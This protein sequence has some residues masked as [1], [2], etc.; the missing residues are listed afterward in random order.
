MADESLAAL[1]T[2]ATGSAA[3]ML[4]GSTAARVRA[5]F[6]EAWQSKLWRRYREQAEEDRGFYVGGEGQWAVGD[7]KA[8]LQ[9]IK[10]LK[11]AAV[12]YNHCQSVV[13]VLTGTERQNRQEIKA[14]PQG[15][16]DVE[17]ARILTWLLKFVQDQTETPFKVSDGFDDGIIEG[18]HC[19]KVGIDFSEDPARGEIVLDGLR[20]GF[21][22]IWDPFW[23]DY[24][25]RDAR[26]VLEFK[27]VRQD[28]LIRDYPDKADLIRGATGDLGGVL[29][30]GQSQSVAGDDYGGVRD[31]IRDLEL[32]R[33]FYDRD[34]RRLLV[35]EAWWM[36]RERVWLVID[37]E[38]KH[39]QETD[40]EAAARAFAAADRERYRVV[41]RYRRRA[42]T[43]TVLPA[44]FETLEEGDTAYGNDAQHYPYVPYLAYRKGDEVYGI[45][46]NLKDPQR[47]GNKRES[48]AI[49]L[50]IRLANMRPT[51][52]EGSLVNPNDL[53]DQH[54]TKPVVYRAGHPRPGWYVPEGI[55]EL[56]RML[57]AM[58]DRG[59]QAVREVSGVETAMLGIREADESGIAIARRM[60]QSQLTVTSLFDN[61]KRTKRLLGHRLARR[62][63]QHF[64]FE[65]TLRL[66][67]EQ[68]QPLEVVVNAVEL[69]GLD[70]DEIRRRRKEQAAAPDG[71]PHVLKDLSALKYDIVISDAPE[72]PTARAAALL[73]MLEIIRAVPALAPAL[74][75]VLVEFMDLPEH[76]KIVERVRRL[77]PP[78][79]TGEPAPQP[80]VEIGGMPGGGALPPGGQMSPGAVPGVAPLPA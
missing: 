31:P 48:A 45:I 19:F 64:S 26:Y 62:I 38:T 9:R 79:L 11:R 5:W 34:S 46:R 29:P 70:R 56:I 68:G 33:L 77:V 27:Q 66:T 13:N 23:R 10:D 4:G 52:E 6:S 35:V 36:E 32:S 42:K 40:S 75:D 54:S 43:A 25:L 61:L 55:G 57:T 21:D 63:Q 22:V 76:Q 39:I 69:A 72:S 50:L 30:G 2:L 15:G 7:D 71:R 20:P 1:Q 65:E 24:G 74:I 59:K 80:A 8:D 28:D 73:T 14:A 47:V 12:T 51:Y 16:E 49:D 41:G 60:G 37:D 67:N 17:D 3:D 58:S 18:L 44:L 78:E 53:D